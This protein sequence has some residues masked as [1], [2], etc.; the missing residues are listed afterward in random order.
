M[1][2]GTQAGKQRNNG[3]GGPSTVPF[4]PDVTYIISQDVGDIFGQIDVHLQ[5]S[6]NFLSA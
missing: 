4:M 2:P 3:I 6:W 5:I 1:I